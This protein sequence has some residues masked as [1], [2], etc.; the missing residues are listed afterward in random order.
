MNGVHG[1]TDSYYEL[2]DPEDVSTL[3]AGRYAILRRLWDAME[4]PASVAEP[5]VLD[6]AEK[7]TSELNLVTVD[8]GVPGWEG[9]L[10][11]PAIDLAW[12]VEKGF[13]IF[14]V[15]DGKGDPGVWWQSIRDRFS[16]GHK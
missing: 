2:V 3:K 15:V 4:D 1:M 9:E 6:Q 8:V 14:D 11:T 7:R 10:A 16:S 12:F 13:F 5:G